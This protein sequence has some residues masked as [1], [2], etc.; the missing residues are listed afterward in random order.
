MNRLLAKSNSSLLL[1]RGNALRSEVLW[2]KK[3]MFLV[4]AG[5]GS[6]RVCTKDELTRVPS[7]RYTR[8]ENKVG[9]EGAE[10]GESLIR[11]HILERFFI[12]LVAGDSLMK[13]RAAARFNDLVGST[14][15][16]EGQPHLV[17]PQRFRQKRAW[18]E[19][20]RI[21][22]AN[23]KVNGFIVEKIRGGYSVAIAGYIAFLPNRLLMSQRL[24]SDKFVIESMNTNAKRRNIVLM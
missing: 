21:W 7:N 13:Q 17:L 18:Q 15:V 16:V 5:L 8:F 6:P 22:R 1:C 4:D 12:D 23:R 10:A 14:D 11:P 20:N 24:S 9:Y 19:L 2:L 3:D